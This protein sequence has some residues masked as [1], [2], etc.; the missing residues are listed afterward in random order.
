M[1]LTRRRALATGVAFLTIFAF[2]AGA[3]PTASADLTDTEWAAN[4]EIVDQVADKL[5]GGREDAEAART[6]PW[7]A[8]VYLDVPNKAVILGYSGPESALPDNGFTAM[9]QYARDRGATLTAVPTGGPSLASMM[10]AQSGLSAQMDSDGVSS[11]SIDVNEDATGLLVEADAGDDY[12]SLTGASNRTDGTAAYEK[13]LRSMTTVPIDFRAVAEDRLPKHASRQD[14]STP[15]YG[16]IGLINPYNRYC[17]AAFG[18]RRTAGGVTSHYLMTAWH[19]GRGVY[20]D[21]AGQT[22]GSSPSANSTHEGADVLAIKLSSG[23]T[24]GSRVYDGSWNSGSYSKP[25][26]GTSRARRG[27]RFCSSGAN[28][29]IHCSLRVYA[30][31]STIKYANPTQKVMGLIKAE[32]VGS[33]IAVAQGDSGGPVIG[34]HLGAWDSVRAVGVISGGRIN[35]A[36][37][38]LATSTGVRCFKRIYWQPVQSFLTIY[39]AQLVTA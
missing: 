9:K 23:Y 3:P 28:S 5:L 39:D 1:T 36:C 12:A 22:L 15:F 19:C 6:Y 18:A 4:Q 38:S 33:G 8:N 10:D 13:R 7:F 11:Y 30:T 16:G 29:G 21:R 31:A 24:A 27:K 14:D 25:V 32:Q 37:P 2:Q 34:P 20:K 26:R 17:S 35:L